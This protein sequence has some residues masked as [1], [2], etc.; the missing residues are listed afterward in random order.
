MPWKETCVVDQRVRFIA[1]L[2][3]DLGHDVA[4]DRNQ[5]AI[6]HATTRTARRIAPRAP[7]GMATA[8][9]AAMPCLVYSV[10]QPRIRHCARKSCK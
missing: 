6:S 9:G 7:V 2:Q 8:G 4:A 1:A 3:E 5:Y 10:R